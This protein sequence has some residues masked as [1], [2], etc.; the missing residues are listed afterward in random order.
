MAVGLSLCAA[1]GRGTQS[2]RPLV[3]GIDLR[4]TDDAHVVDDSAILDGL[5]T[6]DEYDPSLLSRDLERV[7]RYYRARGYYEAKVSAARVLQLDG[8]HVKIEIRVVPGAPVTVRSV[9]IPGLASLPTVVTKHVLQARTLKV[10]DVFDEARFDEM[11]AAM[12]EAQQDRGFPFAKVD[13]KA[14]IDLVEHRAD[15][16]LGLQPGPRATYGAVSIDGLKS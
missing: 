14:H 3:S 15:V 5:A 6:S 7:E 9:E 10:D 11:K 8:R 4:D 1:C 12:I 13:A 2:T 16:T